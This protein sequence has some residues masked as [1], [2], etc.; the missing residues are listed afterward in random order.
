MFTLRKFFPA[1]V[2]IGSLAQ[3]GV[4]QKPAPIDAVEA[5]LRRHVEYLASGKLEGR[6]TGETGATAAAGYVAKQFAQF[7]LKP[8][9]GSANGKMRFLQPFPYVAGVTLGKDNS[10]RIVL[11]ERTRENKLE[12]G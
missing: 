10:L 7:K 2:L 5:N 11:S 6:R 1:I 4:A 9:A 3:T 12:I 8:G